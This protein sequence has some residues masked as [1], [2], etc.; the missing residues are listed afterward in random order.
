[1]PD[2]F[3]ERCGRVVAVTGRRCQAGHLIRDV[4][5]AR[6]RRH[7]RVRSQPMSMSDYRSPMLEL[8]GFSTVF[9]QQPKKPALPTRLAS[10]AR[11]GLPTRERRSQQAPP[12][13]PPERSN[14]LV[15]RLWEASAAAE[16]PADDWFPTQTDERTVPG[17]PTQRRIHWLLLALTFLLVIGA[18][19]LYSRLREIP[20]EDAAELRVVYVENA[21]VLLDTLPAVDSTVV[22]LTNPAV[23][24]SDLSAGAQNLSSFGAGAADLETAVT[25]PLPTVPPLAPEEPIRELR[26]QRAPLQ[27]AAAVATALHSE[28]GDVLA[29]RTALDESFQLP[30]LPVEADE[31]TIADLRLALASTVA[32]SQDGVASLPDIQALADHRTQ[33]TVLLG[34]LESWQVEYLNALERGQ[35]EATQTLVFEIQERTRQLRA[36]IGEPLIDVRIGL[37]QDLSELEA[38]LVNGIAGLEGTAG[39]ETF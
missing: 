15:E 4:P 9:E 39:V 36:A 12:P 23:A 27:E 1:M 19:L 17:V 35:I 30:I 13:P 14:Q 25:G 21:E 29:Y 34:R 31:A 26:L 18:W 6:N 28:M 16:T 32:A 7:R 5:T 3:C 38:L 24:A 8:L 37:E 10:A 2:A 11:A 33:A 20:A 22:F